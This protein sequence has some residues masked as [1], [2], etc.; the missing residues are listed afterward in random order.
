MP[1]AKTAT[2]RIDKFEIVSGALGPVPKCELEVRPLTVLVGPQGAGK[3]LIAQVLYALEEL[4]FLVDVAK[5]VRGSAKLTNEQLFDWVLSHL[6]SPERKFGVFA[7]PN[8]NVRWTRGSQD[9]WPEAAP[10]SFGFSMYS[11]TTQVTLKKPEKDFLAALRKPRRTLTA[12]PL[13]HAVYFPTERAAIAGRRSVFLSEPLTYE[14][15]EHWL[16][17]HAQPEISS[18]RGKAPDPLSRQIAELSEAELGGRAR[19]HGE[20]W[21]WDVGGRRKVQLDLDMAS[22]GQRANFS[23]P[24]I[25]MSLPALRGTGDIANTITLY[26]EEPE[27]SLHPEAQWSVMKVIALLVNAGFRA[28]IT[29]HSL[30]SIY[31]LNNLLQSTRVVEEA[32]GLPDKAMRLRAEDVSV[33]SLNPDQ[34]PEDLVDRTTGFIDERA[35]GRVGEALSGELSRISAHL[36]PESVEA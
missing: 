15:F 27:L 17:G 24:Y 31:A 18:W 13:H 14:L 12:G 9:E 3:S 4:P 21:K 20:R 11:A 34:K 30:T 35:L 16:E 1:S 6:R 36:P 22:S 32:P 29:T 10:S 33:W 25:A 28:V 23:I 19:K 7:S 26:I 5:N 8:V 2:T